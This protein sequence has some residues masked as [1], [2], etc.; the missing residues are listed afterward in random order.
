MALHHS[1]VISQ[2]RG[3]YWINTDINSPSYCYSYGEIV[4]VVCGGLK[5]SANPF[6]IDFH[7]G[8]AYGVNLWDSVTGVFCKAN[9]SNTGEIL[10]VTKQSDSQ[11]ITNYCLWGT[12]CARGKVKDV[13][14]NWHGWYSDDVFIQ[15][16]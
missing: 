16:I 15:T 13:A 5:P 8:G 9:I 7:R 11:I 4:V 10:R 6:P 12:F 14:D 3:K 1:D 2:Y